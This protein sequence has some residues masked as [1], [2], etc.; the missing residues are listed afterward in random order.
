MLITEA[1][2]L[3]TWW[4]PCTNPM[5][6]VAGLHCVVD[7]LIA[8]PEKFS[9]QEQRGYWKSLKTILPDIPFGEVTVENGGTHRMML[10]A[11]K[12]THKGNIEV[13]ELYAL[14]PYPL[15]GLSRGE[16]ETGINTFKFRR[17]QHYR[18]WGQDEIFAAHL[19]LAED[20]A[21]GLTQRFGTWADGFRFPA[22]WG[23]NFDWIPDQDHGGSGMIALQSMLLQPVGDK[24]L[25][26]PAWPMDW[27]VDFKLHAPQSTFVE[28]RVENSKLVKL[29][30]TTKK[31]EIDIFCCN[32][33]FNSELYDFSATCNFLFGM[34]FIGNISSV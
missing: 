2:A 12:Y 24:L 34:Y 8:L 5:P 9:T 33:K 3:E 28:C 7:R 17:D 14:F 19:G 22:F 25:I 13:P 15:F 32:H 16:L 29:H 26:L 23:P 21:R 4:F 1:T 18:G 6:D 30:V 27:D 20:A 10:P 31:R 11:M